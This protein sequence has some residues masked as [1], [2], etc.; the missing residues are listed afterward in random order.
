[1]YPAL[2]K[3]IHWESS[4]FDFTRTCFEFSHHYNCGTLTIT[5]ILG[6]SETNRHLSETRCQKIGKKLQRKLLAIIFDKN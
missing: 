3:N 4:A 2:E 5:F 6:K 1:M